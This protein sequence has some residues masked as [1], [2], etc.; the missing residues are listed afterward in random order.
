VQDSVLFTTD[1]TIGTRIS[2]KWQKEPVI[3]QPAHIR[4]IRERDW[5]FA[6]YFDPD[7]PFDPD[8]R[9]YELYDLANDPHELHN[10]G[11]PA[12]TEYYDRAK[13]LEMY[14]KLVER[15]AETHTTPGVAT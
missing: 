7:N 3:K 15:M 5:K 11:D 12:N 4:C 9:C 14:G 6:L 10:M 1:E 13:V 8:Y 2:R